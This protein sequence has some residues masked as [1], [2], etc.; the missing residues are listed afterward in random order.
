[1][2]GKNEFEDAHESNGDCYNFI[3]NGEK[4]AMFGKFKDVNSYRN[5]SYDSVIALS[6]KRGNI[7]NS[8]SIT[9]ISEKFKRLHEYQQRVKKFL[10]LLIFNFL[11]L[12]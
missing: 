1:M 6:K 11:F 3:S 5:F 2:N 8:I 4:L 12:C 10:Q 9:K 7:S